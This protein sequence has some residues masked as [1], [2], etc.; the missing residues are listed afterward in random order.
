[1]PAVIWY[2]AQSGARSSAPYFPNLER[3]AKS[4]TAS[5]EVAPLEVF[6]LRF[7]TT[8]EILDAPIANSSTSFPVIIF[9]PGN[10]TNVEFY[11]GIA[12]ELASHGYLLIGLNHPYDVAAVSLQDG[13][14][15]QFNPGPV[16]FQAHE[17]WIAGRVDERTADV[18]FVI[19]HLEALNSSEDP[20]LAGHLNLAQL[21]AMGH[22]L[23]GI[24]A[25]EACR[26]SAELLACLNLDGIQRGGPFSTSDH[27][28]PP[29]QP[30]M[31]ITKEPQLPPKTIALFEAIP[32]GS[33]RVVIHQAIHESFTDGPIL[34]PSLLPV[35]NAADRILAL[36]RSYSLAFF[37]QT[38][39]Q[40][41]S[42][43]LEALFQSQ[44][45]SLEVY[46]PKQT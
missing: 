37:Y 26:G 35:P 2:P 1:V 39:K 13:S 46:P 27:P 45:V 20:L 21:S 31:M 36:T 19:E 3:V 10:G 40:Q 28:V 34:I 9:S 14:I 11:A 8:Q 43:I 30:F 22:S 17:A 33:Y 4:L 25:A 18:L 38:L 24:A 7:I 42:P 41:P 32:A 23:G 16:E 5:G 15:A 29:N 44:A 6:G 12:E